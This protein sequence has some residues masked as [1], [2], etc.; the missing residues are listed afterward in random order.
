MPDK[1]ELANSITHGIGVLF[2]IIALWILVDISLQNANN[3]QL[4]SAL[5]YGGSLIVL[6]LASTLY[7]SVYEVSLKKKF[8]Q[9]DHAAIYFLMGGTYTPFTIV[10][11]RDQDWWGW[12]LF[13]VIWVL[14]IAGAIIKLTSMGKLKKVSTA[15][16]LG[17]GWLAIIAIKPL[18]EGLSGDGLFWLLAGGLSYSVGVIFYKWEKLPFNH[19]IWHLF[20]LGGSVFHFYCVWF[21][22]YQ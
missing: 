10:L 11:L 21:Y 5:L 3:W 22:V 7:H 17:I 13:S 19:A 15:L 16:Y 9:L 6:Y 2:G 14:S 20:V 4:V 18:Y 12:G 1:E 8:R